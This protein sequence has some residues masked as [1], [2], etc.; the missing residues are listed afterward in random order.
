MVID[1]TSF[2]LSLIF[3][4]IIVFYLILIVVRAIIWGDKIYERY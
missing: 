1:V 2:Y 4:H 3:I